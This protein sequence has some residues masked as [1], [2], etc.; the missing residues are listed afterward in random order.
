MTVGPWKP[1]YLEFYKNRISDLHI[2]SDVESKSFDV[3]MTVDMSFSNDTPGQASIT[4]K[5]PDGTIVASDSNIRTNEGKTRVA[6]SFKGGEVQ[7]WYPV[8]YGKQ[9]I[10]T[11]EADLTDEVREF[12]FQLRH[13]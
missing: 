6:F 9:P 7:L 13:S 11:V 12:K 4:F 3:K 1:V 10:Y 5:A 8:G 2:R